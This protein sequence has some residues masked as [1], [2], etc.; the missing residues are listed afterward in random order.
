MCFYLQLFNTAVTRAKEWLVVVGDAFT[1]ASVGSNRGCW[2][3]YIRR[4]RAMKGFR[5]SD[6]TEQ[7]FEAVLSTAGRT[8]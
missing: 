6:A 2:I 7:D 5:T 3:E 4:C 1:L 8:R